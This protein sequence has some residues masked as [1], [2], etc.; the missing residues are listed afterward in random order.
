[1]LS[2]W[3]LA[4]FLSEVRL[5]ASTED[6]LYHRIKKCKVSFPESVSV[7][8]VDLITNIFR[9][10]PSERLSAADVLEHPFFK[11]EELQHS[12]DS[13]CDQQERDSRHQ[14]DDEDIINRSEEDQL[15]V[16]N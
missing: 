15:K 9:K 8:F 2:E 6:E 16:T 4:I 7:E 1:M 13:Y 10:E 5:L 3:S 12:D 11:E 14:S